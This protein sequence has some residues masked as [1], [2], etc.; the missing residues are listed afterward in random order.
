MATDR[1]ELGD[2]GVARPS[3]G[4]GALTIGYHAKAG[5]M[6]QATIEELLDSDAGRNL[7]GKVQLIFTS[8]PFPLNRK[9]RYGNKVGEAYLQW[10]KDLAPQLVKLLTPTGSLVIEIGNAWE[11]GKPVMS[12]LGL[13]TL[14]DFLDAG[15]LY[16]CEQFV[17]HNP[18][19]LPS[20][21]QWV[22]VERI[23]VKDSFTHVWW[24]SPSERPDADNTRVLTPYSKA[25]KDLLDRG[26]YNHGKRDSGFDIGEKSFLKDNG[27]AI[28]PNVLTYS[29]TRSNDAYRSFCRKHGYEIHP[30]P[31]AYGLIE[32]FVKFLTKGGELVLDPFAGSNSTGAVAQQLGRRWL[33]T[34]P[35]QQYVEGSMGRFIEFHDPPPR[36]AVG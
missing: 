4:A 12:T 32:F 15:D 17:C 18:A 35:K 25:M 24:M 11:P 10:L 13:R 33:A 9:K 1:A 6:Y 7:K 20:P 16:L 21:A 29:N 8:P 3:A 5:T 26:S 14:L 2:W 28:P 27:G 19:R 31:M 22:N 30:A 34:E 36:P 23:R